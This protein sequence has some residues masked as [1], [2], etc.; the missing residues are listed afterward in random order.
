VSIGTHLGC[1]KSILG[2]LVDVS[3]K[4]KSKNHPYPS[5]STI[6]HLSMNGLKI[7]M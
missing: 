6:N 2:T 3:D 1:Y 4:L 7:Y 5:A